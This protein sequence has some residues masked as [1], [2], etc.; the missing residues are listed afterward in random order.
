[1]QSFPEVSVSCRRFM[2]LV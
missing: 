2:E 1:M